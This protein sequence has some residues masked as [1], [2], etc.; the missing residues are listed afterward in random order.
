MP[1]KYT[2]SKDAAGKFRFSLHGSNGQVLVTS[3][4]YAT[5]RGAMIGLAAVRRNAGAKVEETAAP[6]TASKTAAKRTVKAIAKTTPAKPVAK[7]TSTRP[8]KRA[9]G[10]VANPKRTISTRTTARTAAKRAMSNVS[11]S[12][13]APTPAP[14]SAK[15]VLPVV[16]VQN[17][18]RTATPATV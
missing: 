10:S 2:I 8:A 18:A 7:S 13:P 12:T 4:G 6:K 3:G 9:A 16:P 15:P 17:R 5:R 11:S 14:T 1:A